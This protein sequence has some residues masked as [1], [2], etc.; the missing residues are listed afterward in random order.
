MIFLNLK[1]RSK[2]L[3]LLIG[4][5]TIVYSIVFFLIIN[6]V[7]EVSLDDSRKHVNTVIRESAKSIED[8]INNELI[9]TKTLAE[10]FVNLIELDPEQRENLQKEILLSVFKEHK[11]FNSLWLHWDLSVLNK[12]SQK[13]ERLRT[14]YFWENG[15][16]LFKQDTAT[17]DNL[18]DNSL[19]NLHDTKRTSILEPY[20]FSYRENSEKDQMT[21]LISPIIYEG[22]VVGTVGCDILLDELKHRIDNL[23]LFNNG[24]SF[25]VSNGGVYVTHPDKTLIGQTMEEVNPEEN[26]E[27]NIQERIKKGEAFSIEAIHSET[28]KIVIVY[29]QPITMQSSGTPWCL[30]VMVTL[31]DV[32]ETT[33]DLLLWLIMAGITGI[34]VVAIV[35]TIIANQIST[36]VGKGARYANTL[37]KGKFEER[38]EVEGNDEVSQL[39]LSLSSMAERIGEIFGGVKKASAEITEAGQFLS[40]SSNELSNG[41]LN[42]SEA[43]SE[44]NQSVK[45]LSTT[46]D[47]NDKSAHKAREITSK[48]VESIQMGSQVSQQ[49]IEA[50]TKVA[51]RIQ[52]VNDIAFQTNILALNAAVEAARA[53]E[54]G[55]GFAV[56]AAEVRK[57]AERSKEAAL[58]IVSLSNASLSTIENVMNVMNNLVGE[59]D[60]SAKIIASISNENSI[61]LDETQRINSALEKLVKYG[62]D[63]KSTANEISDY[64]KQLLDL[65]ENLEENLNSFNE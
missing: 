7:K 45:L 41:T 13:R 37:S 2:M 6:S 40:K 8:Q 42:L 32:M 52:V 34:V 21:S 60:E 56:V 43:T 5:S 49:A 15:Q 23:S 55:K 26:K 59:I 64:S 62:D 31:D 25:L 30:G 14:K 12:D 48:S 22:K 17:F 63:N 54:H 11:N 18:S 57:L 51:E 29:F 47:K 53:G 3:I 58:D 50:M 65:S 61:L 39:A 44:V 10:S 24:Y 33:E 19:W 16:I 20:F 27:Y 1:I 36:R 9:V 35:I 4:G 38:I 28:R 46:I